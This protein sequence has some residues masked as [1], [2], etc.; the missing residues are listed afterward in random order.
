MAICAW[1]GEESVDEVVI[2]PPVFTGVG[3]KRRLKIEAFK[4]PVCK[5]HQNIVRNQPA[6]YTCGCSY[7][8]GQGKC[9]IHDNKL[10]KQFT[11]DRENLP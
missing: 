11:D 7:V 8:K 6:F 9:P 10:R 5:D 4:V 3:Q 1:C 2:R